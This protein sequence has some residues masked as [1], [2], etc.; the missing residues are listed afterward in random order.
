MRMHRRCVAIV[1]SGPEATTAIFLCHNRRKTHISMPLGL[2]ASD[3]LLLSRVRFRFPSS[4]LQSAKCLYANDLRDYQS[5]ARARHS[6]HPSL[7]QLPND[8]KHA[9]HL[10]TNHNHLPTPTTASLNDYW[11]SHRLPA[12]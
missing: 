12:A 4:S 5:Q 10:G 8:S 11:A 1:H 2:L 7:L 3:W 9:A 6:P